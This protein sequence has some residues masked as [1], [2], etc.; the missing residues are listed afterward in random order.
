EGE[1]GEEEEEA[2]SGGTDPACHAGAP[3]GGSRAAA[4]PAAACPRVRQPRCRPRTRLDRS[5][6]PLR[7]M[8]YGDR[9]PPAPSRRPSPA[10]RLRVYPSGDTRTKA[11]APGKGAAAGAE[12]GRSLSTSRRG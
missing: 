11:A 6:K 2:A 12:R 8:E 9:S 3:A 10:R 7:R 1:G 4:G 5:R